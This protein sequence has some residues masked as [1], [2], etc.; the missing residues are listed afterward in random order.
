MDELG[1]GERM[2]T[3]MSFHPLELERLSAVRSL[4][5]LD[6]E[7]IPELQAAARMAALICAAP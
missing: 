7:A 5:V 2:N 1:Q 4:S 3:E 6:T